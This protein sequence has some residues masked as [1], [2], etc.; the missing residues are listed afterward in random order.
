MKLL[1]PSRREFLVAFAAAPLVATVPAFAADPPPAPSLSAADKAD[2]ARVEAYLNALRTMQAHFLQVAEN[3]AT[4][5]GQFYLS[6]PGKLRLE[7]D[8]PVPILM[9]SE[10]RDFLIHYD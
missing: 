1:R 5:Q 4:A 6:R 7:Y 8:P 9:I 10:G 2:I 3:G